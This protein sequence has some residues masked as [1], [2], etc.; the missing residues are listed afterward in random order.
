MSYGGPASGGG[1]EAEL[2]PVNF[3]DQCFPS[4]ISL[5]P[6]AIAQDEVGFEAAAPSKK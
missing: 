2:D 1:E 3:T 4:Y 6:A 5:N